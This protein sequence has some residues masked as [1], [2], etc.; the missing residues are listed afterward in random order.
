MEPCF[1][2]IVFV[3]GTFQEGR[4][5][6]RAGGGDADSARAPGRTDPHKAADVSTPSRQYRM[7]GGFGLE[8]KRISNL[9]DALWT[10]SEPPQANDDP[11]FQLEFGELLMESQFFFMLAC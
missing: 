5:E 7:T 9:V 3:P 2:V 6:T 4:R 11:R 1:C 10:A 8:K